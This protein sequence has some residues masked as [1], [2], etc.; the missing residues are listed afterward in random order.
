MLVIERDETLVGFDRQQ[1][2]EFMRAARCEQSI[3][4]VHCLAHDD[5]LLGLPD[6]V[7]WC[8]AKGGHWRQRV[9]PIIERVTNV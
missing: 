4:Y 3:R 2:I 6:A 8:W 7:A 9:E 5:V 1:L